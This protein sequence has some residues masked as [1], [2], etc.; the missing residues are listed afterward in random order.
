[1]WWDSKIACVMWKMGPTLE[2]KLRRSKCHHAKI[3][4]YYELLGDCTTLNL[5]VYCKWQFSQCLVC[6]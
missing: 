4:F 2:E 3:I 1:M 6:C 5:M